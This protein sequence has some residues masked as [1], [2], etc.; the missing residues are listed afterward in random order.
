MS[1]KGFVS[2]YLLVIQLIRDRSFVSYDEI[3]DEVLKKQDWFDFNETDILLDFSKRTLQRDIKDIKDIFGIDIEYSRAQKGYSIS[4]G[5]NE[6]EEISRLVD[7]YHLFQVNQIHHQFSNHILRSDTNPL[8]AH[9]L[10]LLLKAIDASRMVN[11]QYK[12][13]WSSDEYEVEVRPLFIKEYKARWYLIAD[14][15]SNTRIY[16]LD[17]FINLHISN[18]TFQYDDYEY[19]K[20]RLSYCY[21]II[22]EEEAEPETIQLLFNSDQGNYI[23]TLPLHHS[24]RVL[25]DDSDGLLVEMKVYITYDLIMDL[26]RYLASII[27]I[28]P[29]ILMDQVFSLSKE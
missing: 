9:F 17:R 4:H 18:M 6:K 28:E 1:K 2:R 20:E 22:Y 19:L 25:K 27:F 3:R 16:A 5:L 26:R 14:K 12:P 24:Q 23:K 10:P 13:F 7:T 15:T 11:I 29:K 8:G 21:G